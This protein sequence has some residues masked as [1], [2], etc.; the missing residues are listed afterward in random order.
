MAV[1]GLW[2]LVA[3]HGVI[4]ALRIVGLAASNAE[5]YFDEAQYWAWSRTLE[6]GYFS[7][8]PLLAWIIAAST[9]VCGDTEFCVRLPSPILHMLTALVVF[10]IASRLFDR[11]VGFWSS[12]IYGLIPGVSLSATLMSTDVPLLLFWTLAML[13]L[14]SHVERPS[15]AAGAAIGLAMG[16]GLNAKYA[17]IYFPLCFA[18]FAAFS[19]R[20]RAAARHPG[21][22]LAVG[23]AVLMILPNILWNVWNDFATFE[24]TRQNADWG[25]GF[26]NIIGMLEFIGIQAVIMW[27]APFVAYLLAVR[28]GSALPVDARR[29]MIACSAPV[30]L[31]VIAQAL[32]SRAHGNWAATAFPAAVILATAYMIAFDWRGMLR[33]TIALSVVVL[34]TLSFYGVLVG[35]V[36][37]G[38]LGRQFGK[39]TGWTDFASGVAAVASAN[40]L[41]TVVFDGRAVTASMTWE[42]RRSGLDVRAY[43]PAATA[44]GDHFQQTA[45]WRPSDPGPVLFV[46]GGAAPPPD[47]AARATLLATVPAKMD[48]GRAWGGIATLYRM[49]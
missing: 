2:L 37:T 41:G 26:P 15:L 20:A 39:L 5:L 4:L 8:P 25:S 21:T 16:L 13:G 33:T 14:V 7:K 9:S 1:P 6:F 17:M 35:T 44:P 30:F 49:E 46:I 19:A 10:A 48:M 3:I 42:L 32:I 47:L 38:P 12:L 23:I 18:A 29:M 34:V 45:P 43:L 36:T 31:V 28:G 11:A 22:A 40:G 24:H 27:P